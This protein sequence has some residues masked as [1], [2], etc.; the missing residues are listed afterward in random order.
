MAGAWRFLIR[1]YTPLSSVSIVRSLSTRIL[2]FRDE[3]MVVRIE[4]RYVP[5]MA[6]WGVSI[7][8]YH[9]LDLAGTQLQHGMCICERNSI[10]VHP[11]G[12]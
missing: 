7:G 10:E 2:S 9:L 8:K 6:W 12:M 4:V 3:S 11:E 5:Q 1:V